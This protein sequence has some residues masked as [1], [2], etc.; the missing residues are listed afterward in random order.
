[1]VA[2]AIAWVRA[3]RPELTPD[4]A[5]QAVRLSAVDLGRRG[6]GADTGF[7]LLNVE[8]ALSRPASLADPLE[9]NDSMYW[10]DGRAFG[11]PDGLIFKG[12]RTRRLGATIDVFEDPADVYRIR[13]RRHSR[14]KISADPVRTD[15]VALRVYG[16]KAG[17][18]DAKPLKRSAR[19]GKRTERITLR[20]RSGRARV[21]YVAVLVQGSRDLDAAYAL[22]VG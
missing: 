20:N 15:D 17:S 18:L 5:A 13:L 21:Y 3:A 19:R 4:Q 6:W 2:A 7:G 22:R 16:R 12:G 8:R 9:P 1:M 10:V 11:Q 14:V